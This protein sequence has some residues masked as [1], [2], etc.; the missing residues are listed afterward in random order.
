V[1]QRYIRKMKIDMCIFDLDGTLIDTS[2]DITSA[3]ND[4]LSHYGL[5]RK[6]VEEVIGYV[7]DGVVK[8]TER[9][10]GDLKV[11]FDEAVKLFREAYTLHLLDTSRPYPGVD[12]MLRTLNSVKKS[13]LTNK[14]YGYTVKL[15]EHLELSSHFELVVGGDTLATKKPSTEGIDHILHE[16]EVD[17]DRAVM[18]GDSRNDILT[19]NRAGIVSIY[20]TWGFHPQARIEELAPDYTVDSPDRIPDLID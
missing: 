11:D 2:T 1:V 3:A 18:I 4:M 20:V 13:V 5:P 8:L 10:L 7:G 19:A 9:C 16:L 14:P 15:L 12:E 17:R 6:S